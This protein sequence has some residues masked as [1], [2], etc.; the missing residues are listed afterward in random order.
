MKQTKENGIGYRISC[1]VNFGD[2]SL[3]NDLR[4]L[5]LYGCSSHDKFIPDDYKYNSIDLR[6][7]LIQGLMDTH[8]S[9][10]NGRSAEYTTVSKGLA[11]DF[12]EIV[13]SLG[14]TAKISQRSTSLNGKSFSSSR[15][16]IAG[17]NI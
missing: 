17:N 5:N 11:Y 10:N 6:Y 16:Y 9:N 13:Q 2:N 4:S 1:C 3:I 7:S 15:I 8:G 12:I 14:F